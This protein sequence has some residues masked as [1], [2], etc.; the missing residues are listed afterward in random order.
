M[1]NNIGFIQH[2]DAIV[3]ILKFR[4]LH[5]DVARALELEWMNI[6]KEWENSEL[7]VSTPYINKG[8]LWG[9]FH[10]NETIFYITPKGNAYFEKKRAM[11]VE[12]H[13]TRRTDNA[14]NT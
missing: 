14:D 7:I 8:I 10:R 3:N 5:P 1:T 11:L 2:L 12:Q 6:I 9:I 4:L 13:F